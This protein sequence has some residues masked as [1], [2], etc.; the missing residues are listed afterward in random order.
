MGEPKPVLIDGALLAEAES[1]GLEVKNLLESELRRQVEK[2]RVAK[3]W[4]EKNRE[5]VESYNRYIDESG[6]AGGE[7]RRYD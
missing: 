6:P 2:E 5:F 3:E 1:L 4:A 7:Y